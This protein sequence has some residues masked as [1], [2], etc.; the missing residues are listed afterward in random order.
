MYHLSRSKPYN[1][2]RPVLCLLYTIR[3][4]VNAISQFAD[5]AGYGL[6]IAGVGAGL[7]GVLF[8]GA[9]IV[10]QVEDFVRQHQGG[11][12]HKMGFIG[13]GACPGDFADAL[14]DVV[15]EVAD[16]LFLAIVAGDAVIASV[17]RKGNLSHTLYS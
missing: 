5:G 12:D 11:Q 16:A 4:I 7:L 14:V 2:Y 17:N 1:Q 10:A 3:N 6:V 8:K 15:T 9:H 13:G